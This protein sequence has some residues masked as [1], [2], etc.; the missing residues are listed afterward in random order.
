MSLLK[1]DLTPLDCFNWRR[2]KLKNPITKYKINPN[3]PIYKEIEKKCFDV[4]SPDDGIKIDIVIPEKKTFL[5]KRKLTKNDCLKWN[6]NK[7][8]NPITNY[9]IKE[10]GHVYKEIKAECNKILKDNKSP[11]KPPDKSSSSIK[12]PD[13]SSSSIKPLDKSSSSIKDDTE[14]YYPDLDDENFREKLAKLYEFNMHKILEF[15]NINTINDFNTYSSKLCSGFDK[16]YYQY[17]MGHYISYRSPYKSI[18]IYHSVGVGKTCSAITIAESFLIPHDLYEEPKIWVI[19]PKS[20]ENSFKEQIFN[21]AKM[22]DFSTIC[23]QCTGNI[24]TKLANITK[25]SNVEKINLRIKKLIKSRYRVF[26]YDG[27]ASFI[28]NEYNNKQITD[29]VIIVDEAHNI[30][31]TDTSDK[32]IYNTLT[33]ILENGINNRLVLLSATPMYNEP[34]D[35]FD[36]LYLLLLNDKRNHLLKQP[37]PAIFDSNNNLNKDVVKLLEKLSNNYISYLIGKN[38]FTFAFKLS[39]FKSGIKVLDKPIRLS[40]N[41]NPIP[42]TDNDWIDK[43]EDGI[44]PSQLGKYQ[45]EYLEKNK[46]ELKNEDNIFNSLQPMNIVYNTDIGETGFYTIFNRFNTNEPLNVKYN[47]Q[48]NSAFLPDNNHLAHFSGKLLNIANIIKNTEGVIVIYSR[49]IWSGILP[50]A[51]I[52]EH[53]GFNREGTTNFLDKPE[54]IIDK[55]KYNNIRIPKYCILSSSENTEIMGSTNID[56]LLK[57]INNPLN[58]DGSIIK[59]ILMTPVAGEGLS[60]SNI[61]EMHLLEPWYHFNRIDQVIGRGIRNCSHKLLPI[62]LKNVTVFMHGAINGYDKETPDIHA[63]RISSRKLNQSYEINKIIKNNSIDCFYFKNINYFNKNLFININPI[64]IKTSQQKYIDYYLGD[65]I[66]IEPKCY[67]NIKKNNYDGFRVETFNNFSI[68]IKNKLRKIILNEIHNGNNFLSLQQ[69][70]DNF[71]DIHF[72]II[73]FVINNSIFPNTLIDGYILIP[74]EDGIHIVR[75]INNVP[76]KI[77]IVENKKIEKKDDIND[78]P[79]SIINNIEKYID[80]DDIN[81]AIISL[82]SSLDSITFDF[83]VKKIITSI[84]L[85]DAEK[86]IAKCLYHEGVLISNNEIKSIKS[87]TP[88]FIGYCNIFSSKFDPI[89]Y[90]NNVYRDFNDTQIAELLSSR[91]K[92]NIPDMSKETLLWGLFIPTILDK[93]K[94]IYNNI[95]KILTPGSAIGKKTG[96]ACVSLKKNEHANIFKQLHIE[97]KHNTKNTYCKNIAIQLLNIQ[98]IL[99]YPE[100]K[101]TILL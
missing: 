13:K 7:F 63:Y 54:I 70:I 86:F 44:V 92:I 74:H 64:K 20:L 101:P 79:E 65:D 76:L 95:F 55:P 2:N 33:N 57:L 46:K 56:G 61:R 93:D 89:I 1:R 52:L 53:L 10:N 19:M 100:Y 40:I 45:I 62:E 32:R 11:I 14:L 15:N 37:Y 23:N 47:S 51:I 39:P 94:N 66:D 68:N 27:F 28:E 8:K 77:K 75:I 34:S 96:I 98:R 41:N 29:K 17:F 59:V 97:D 12:P 72:D 38:P 49:F 90:N 6:A 81:N 36:L 73:M 88:I 42:I 48:Y 82:Y 31:S 3:S 26:T 87:T 78:I 16:A 5:T 58:I 91:T 25:D 83:I 85:S 80:T 50:M 21:I 60:F 67:I 30:R 99:L 18:L 22:Q 24:Y 71:I 35:I 84:H 4:K 69:I 9:T 43:I